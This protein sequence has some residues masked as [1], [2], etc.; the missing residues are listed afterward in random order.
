MHGEAETGARAVPG[1]AVG[2][3]GRD[4]LG[5]NRRARLLRR[6]R[7]PWRGQSRTTPT[8]V[9]SAQGTSS[10]AMNIRTRRAD[11]P[12]GAFECEWP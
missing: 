12:A 8:T 5:V 6:G 11:G 9:A 10:A 7:R 2:P 1:C 3:L 4:D